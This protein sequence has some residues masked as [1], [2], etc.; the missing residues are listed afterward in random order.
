M[1]KFTIIFLLFFSQTAFCQEGA[2]WRTIPSLTDW[3]EE[4]NN[5]PDEIYRERNLK[6]LIDPIKDKDYISFS[7]SVAYE[8][9]D[10]FPRMTINKRINIWDIQF[11][12]DPYLFSGLSLKNLHFKER[13]D[14]FR[15]K[16]GRLSFKNC[17]FDNEHQVRIINTL[18]YLAYYDCEF[19]DEFRNNN[20]QEPLDIL[21]YNCR[22]H[23][24]FEL[25]SDQ[26][27]PN[28]YI[29]NS[30]FEEIVS[31][32]ETSKFNTVSIHQSTFKSDLLLS[33]LQI[34]NTLEVIASTISFINLDGSKLPTENTY[35]PFSQISHKIGVQS[36]TD[37][38]YFFAN[39]AEDFSSKTNYDHVIAQYAKLL[40]VYKSR[41]EMDSYNDCYVEM[42]NKQT[43]YSQY[44][45]KKDR[46]FEN[47]LVFSLNRFLS[48]FSDYGTRPSK[49]ILISIY[50][51]LGFA[52]IYLFFPNSW[53]AHGKNRIL[54][55]YRFFI[56]YLQRNAG[57]H[58]VYLE[59]RKQDL[60][61]Y[62][63]FKILIS[64]S[65]K[66]IPRF[67][68]AT[69][70]PLYHWAVSGKR[71]TAK[72]LSKF[73]I[74]K[75]TWEDLPGS[76]KAWK[77][78]LLTGTFLLALTYDLLIKVLN[79]LMLSINTFTT[80]GFGEIPIKGLPRYLAIIQGFIGWFMLT[81]FSVSLISQLL[82]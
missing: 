24:S 69:A 36:L 78:F 74:L 51:I 29:K 23:K 79:A 26:G 20:P 4:V 64:N 67:F 7:D 11:M 45:Y 13:V 8:P 50:V 63:E 53:D 27:I 16:N 58:E 82:N 10:S 49:A 17:V 70:L 80:L 41:S 9:V 46:S 75:G 33:R 55:R 44:H 54:D 68:S 12:G 56:K 39:K 37:Q 73:D 19:K 6:I 57:V 5:W 71:M 31:F 61:G 28:V 81:I 32:N 21:F 77:S 48:V 60:M 65:G 35:L 76:Q 52:L 38:T 15:I 18:F 47:W 25:S 30:T 66:S 3:V 62:E 59:E 34:D 1:K 2:Q 22:F 72:I 43:A 14:F 42:R 40:A